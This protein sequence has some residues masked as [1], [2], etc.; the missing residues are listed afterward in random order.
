MRKA[1]EIENQELAKQALRSLPDEQLRD[2]KK[3]LDRFTEYKKLKKL[4]SVYVEGTKQALENTGNGRIYSTYNLAGAVTGRLSNSGINVTKGGKKEGKLGVSFHTLPREDEDLDVNIR[5]YA[6]AP[7]G[8]KFVTVDFKAMEVRVLAHVAR[9]QN[10]IRAFESGEDLHK[11]SAGLTFGK[12]P[13]VVTKE[14]RQIAKAVT[15]LTVYGGTHYTLA[16]KH[17]I[18]ED[19]A[20]QVIEAWMDAF[21]GV[22]RYMEEVREYL[23]EHQY[24]KTM[25]GRYRHLP[26][27]SSPIKN[28]RQRAFRQGLNFTIQSTASDILLCSLYALN[29]RFENW[30]KTYGR[31]EKPQ[32]VATVHDSIE[33]ICKD[34]DLDLVVKVIKDELLNYPYMRETFGIDLAV[35]MGIDIE[36]GT[37]FGNGVAID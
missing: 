34:E 18:S 16:A 22:G 8:W 19:V 14:E 4:Y 11:F 32:I 29:K 7:P 10:L 36:V 9:E 12:D 31:I 35:P 1:E 27:I 24:V 26:N 23:E 20:Q 30:Y 2:A 5:D 6:V 17:N 15:F 25:F 3:F 21:P 28:I 33:L 37:S 13:A